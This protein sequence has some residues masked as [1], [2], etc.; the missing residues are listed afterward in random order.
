MRHALRIIGA[1]SSLPKQTKKKTN[2]ASRVG[3]SQYRQPLATAATHEA[4]PSPATRLQAPF[5]WFGGKSRAAALLWPR[6]GNVRNYVEPFAGSLAVLL[7]R[8][9]PFLGCETVNDLDGFVGNF[10]RALQADP[11]DVARWADWPVN[12]NDQHARHLWLLDRR[13]TLT[14]RLA[15][16]PAFYDAK[17]AGW[18]VWGIGTWIGSGWCSGKGPWRSDVDRKLVHLGDA[19]RG[20]HRQ[21]VHLGDAGQGVHRQLVHLGDAGQ[22]AWM[23]AL[24]DRLR[25]VR[26][27]CGDWTR[28]SG[29]SVTSKH[30]L[31]AILLDP[32]YSDAER[33]GGL[34]A[35]DSGTIAAAVRVWAIENGRNPQLRIALCGYVGEH[36]MPR[37]WT[38]VPWKARGG[39]GSQGTGRGRANSAREVIWF[40][41]SCLKVAA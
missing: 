14:A 40:S 38:M 24:A 4:A 13:D 19:G 29:P 7:A 35:T 20:V 6:F 30:G 37:G 10:W 34:Y 25:H 21:L 3:D 26:V 31:T 16:D 9:T 36:D 41:R 12:E 8:P 32:P 22:G 15:G 1:A 17:I 18:W 28:V 27:A 23:Q 11:D 5:P 2:Q 33:E 39:Y